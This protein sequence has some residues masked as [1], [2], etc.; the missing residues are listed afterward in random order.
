MK[1]FAA[2]YLLTHTGVLLKNGIAVTGEDG[3]VA[4][5]VDTKDGIQEM[6][7]MIFLSGLLLEA[8]ELI[9]HPGPAIVPVPEDLFQVQL[10][11]LLAHSEH[12]SLQQLLDTGKELQKQFPEMTIP[13]LL[14]RML[15]ILLS[16]AGYMK[17]PLPGLYL[18][19]GLDM[20]K[21]HF[22]PE[23]RVKKIL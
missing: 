23:S 5:Y 16:E 21:L 14:N 2:H 22:T 17:K 7:Q 6:E 8:F 1:R 12:I 18:L 11:Y 10:V 19:K 3:F 20:T 15:A 4:E 9:K 13:D